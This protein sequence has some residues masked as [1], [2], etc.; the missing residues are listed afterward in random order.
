MRWA[1]IWR[2]IR[3]WEGIVPSVI[4]IAAALY[5]GPRKMLETWDWYWDR[6]RDSDV[7][8][9]ISRRKLIQAPGVVL[10][11]I[12]PRM[13]ELPYFAKEI[14][15]YLDR[16]ESSVGRSLKRLM[17]RGKIEPHQDGWRLKT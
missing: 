6:F 11:Q 1:D 9:I 12:P 7:F 8:H 16:K 3:S 15:D 17:K 2:F 13:I 14:A 10:G 4:A 5:Y